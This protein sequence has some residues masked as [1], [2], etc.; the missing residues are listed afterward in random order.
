MR[1]EDK[2]T[3]QTKHAVGA[4]EAHSTGTVGVSCHCLNSMFSPLFK[5]TLHELQLYPASIC[6]HVL[7]LGVQMYLYIH[8]PPTPRSPET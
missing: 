3:V 2:P 4:A 1:I 5:G 8:L 7:Y 6:V